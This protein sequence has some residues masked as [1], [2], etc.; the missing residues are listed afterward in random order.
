MRNNYRQ[1]A[2][3][4]QNS[5]KIRSSQKKVAHNLPVPP[6]QQQLK[7][8]FYTLWHGTTREAVTVSEW[9]NW[10]V[11]YFLTQCDK[12]CLR[13]TAAEDVYAEEEPFS[14]IIKIAFV[15]SQFLE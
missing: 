9:V 5:T 13:Q 7:T 15:F 1:S 4:P 2:L 8:Y 10:K 14:V 6:Q 3:D 11:V 12:S